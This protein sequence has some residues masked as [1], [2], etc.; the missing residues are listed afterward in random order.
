[1]VMTIRM[2]L[3]MMMTIIAFVLLICMMTMMRMMLLVFRFFDA[4]TRQ[5]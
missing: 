3:A 4:A 5:Q 2:E 1:M